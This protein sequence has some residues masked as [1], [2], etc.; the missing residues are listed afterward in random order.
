MIPLPC[1]RKF[2]EAD[3]GLWSNKIDE[4]G[5]ARIVIIDLIVL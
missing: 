1:Y 5:V 3:I 4:H 2:N